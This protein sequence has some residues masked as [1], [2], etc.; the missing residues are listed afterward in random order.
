M[1]TPLVNAL[2]REILIGGT[3]YIVTLAAD[4]LSVRRKGS[5]KSLEIAW[6]DLLTF[7][8]RADAATAPLPAV[9]TSRGS[10]PPKAILN[11]IAQGLRT[12][13]AALAYADDILT[14]SGALPAALMA[15]A[16]SDPT[17]GRATQQDHWFVEPL[18][19]VVEVA[20][21]LR[22]SPRVVRRLGL[23]SISIGGEER[24]QQSVIREYLREHERAS[25]RTNGR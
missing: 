5:R 14:Q 11:E 23:R 18:L 13:A 9:D 16:A 25:Q 4:R 8:Q 3:A 6:D 1:T 17:Y 21:I 22:I 10:A 12:A 19:T 7:E 15:Q 20:S 24:Y 2:S